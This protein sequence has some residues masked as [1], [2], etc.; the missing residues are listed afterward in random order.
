MRSD[1]GEKAAQLVNTERH[2]AGGA[3]ALGPRHMHEYGAAMSCDARARVVRDLDHK[4]VETIAAPQPVAWF[5][6]RAAERA[7]VPTIG[8]ILTPSQCLIDPPHWQERRWPGCA[9]GAPPEAFEAKAPAGRC[10]ITL[11]LVCR[12]ASATKNDGNRLPPGEQEAA[13][14]RRGCLPHADDRKVM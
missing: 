1:A 7:V 12:N 6:G 10:P 11:A 8:R 13:M 3:G 5:T 4:V 9:I 2:A 14:R